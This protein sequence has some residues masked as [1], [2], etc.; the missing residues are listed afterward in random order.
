MRKEEYR[1]MFDLEERMW[2]YRGM[3]SVTATMLAELNA[4]GHG[5]RLLDVGCGTGFS[6]IWLRDHIKANAVFGVDVSEHAVEFWRRRGLNSVALAAVDQLP[7]AGEEFDL[8]TCLD[9]VYQLDARSADDALSE[10]SRVLKPGGALFIREPAY[11]WLRGSHDVAVSTRHRYTR[12][13]LSRSL[14]AHGFRIRRA[15]Y[16]NTFLFPAAVAHR[17]LSKGGDSS[18]V[19][20]ASPILNRVLTSVLELEAGLLKRVSFPFGLSLIALAEKN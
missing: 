10:I 15:S 20:E 11:D 7:F 3:R 9:V 16:A 18:D 6:M 1:A 8:V 19:H 17:V 12:G 2:W 5:C 4:Q 14:E 13:E